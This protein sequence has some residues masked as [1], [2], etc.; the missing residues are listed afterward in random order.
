MKVSLACLP[1]HEP[2]L[3][4]PTLGTGALPDWLRRMPASAPSE[5]L[6]GADVRTVKRCPPFIDAM[7]SGVLFPLAADV[8]VSGGE[9]AWDWDL[10]ADPDW[11]GTRSPIGVHVPEQATGLP[12]ARPDELVVKFTN[13]WTVSL[14]LGW[15]MLFGHPANRPE[16]PFRTLT[17]LVDCD[18]WGAGHVHFPALW[19]DPGFEGTLPAGT[20]VAQGWP[21][22]RDTLELEIGPMD[23]AAVAER[24]ALADALQDAPGLYRKRY[25][26]RR[27]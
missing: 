17:G 14:P 8:H 16:L 25:R 6:A 1:S 19:T 7:R 20:P 2:F 11:S 4:R 22:P 5:V 18:R 13:F 3:A 26:A 10:P 27:G 9:L 15:S 24:A 23:R 12:G 21:V